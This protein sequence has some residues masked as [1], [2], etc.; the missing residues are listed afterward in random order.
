MANARIGIMSDLKTTLE[1]IDGTGDYT[2]TMGSVYRHIRTWNEADHTIRPI[3]CIHFGSEVYQYETFGAGGE[4]NIRVQ[5]TVDLLFY[6]NAAT[7]ATRITALDNL[8]DDVWIALHNDTTRGGNAISTT[9]VSAQSD[10]PDI[11]GQEALRVTL[12]IVYDRDTGVSS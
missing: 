3:A 1:G 7:E 9:I 10:Q 5:L 2:T 4:G 6:L 8:L 12:L 11:D